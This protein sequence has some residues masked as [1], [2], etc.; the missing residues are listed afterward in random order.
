MPRRQN[1]ALY[2]HRAVNST[3]IQLDPRRPR[4]LDTSAP[5]SHPHAVSASPRRLRFFTPSPLLR[6]EMARNKVSKVLKMP[7]LSPEDHHSHH[8]PRNHIGQWIQGRQ[9]A[10]GIA[11]GAPAAVHGAPPMGMG[12]GVYLGVRPIFWVAELVG[13]VGRMMGL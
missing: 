3:T 7:K 1:L 6:I 13:N 4:C 8:Q 12:M 10:A 5:S 11:G 9:A 2:T